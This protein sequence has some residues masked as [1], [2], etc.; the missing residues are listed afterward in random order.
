[1]ENFWVAFAA[2]IVVAGPWKAAIVFAES[3]IPMNEPDRRTTAWWT[4]IIGAAVG[5]VVLLF[6]FA[7]VELFKIETA[8]FLIGAGII[9]VV[10]AVRMVVVPPD[11]EPDVSD[12]SE[13]G[14]GDES[15]PLRLAIYPLAIPMLITPPA[16]VTLTAIGIA[17]GDSDDRL[18]GS[19]VAFL[20]V[21]AFNL[22]VF[23]LLAR[24]EHRVPMA[25]WEVAGRLLGIFLAAFGVS[26]IIKGL[27][28]VPL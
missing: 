22:G 6:G 4:V 24:Y 11:H 12:V 21:M 5:V 8:G 23:L 18:L 14:S 27:E 2:L 19:L 17:V 7:L 10:F 16:V 26:I 20:L 28:A 1:M 15:G 9:V 3:T 25:A 13:E